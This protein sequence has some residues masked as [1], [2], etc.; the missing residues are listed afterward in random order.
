MEFI[1][2]WSMYD[3]SISA[4]QMYN[5]DS[6]QHKCSIVRQGRLNM[7][8]STNVQHRFIESITRQGR[9]S[10]CTCFQTYGVFDDE[11]CTMPSS[12]HLATRFCLQVAPLAV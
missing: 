1:G 5:I 12:N 3:A 7:C 6:V 2:T 11:S 9:F 4:V 10:P 8:I